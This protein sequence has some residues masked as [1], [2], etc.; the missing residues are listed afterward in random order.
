MEAGDESRGIL[1]LLKKSVKKKNGEK[2]CD[3]CV[4]LCLSMVGG[5]SIVL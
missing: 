5:L 4:Y 1:Q 3:C 2:I